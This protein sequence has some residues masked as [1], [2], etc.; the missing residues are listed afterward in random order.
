MTNELEKQFFDTF[1]IEHHIRHWQQYNFAQV[2]NGLKLFPERQKLADE[3]YIKITCNKLNPTEFNDCVYWEEYHYPQITDRI[4]LEL[5]IILGTICTVFDKNVDDL[6]EN[7]LKN[8]I[9]LSGRY[10][11]YNQVRTLFEEGD[12]NDR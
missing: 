4:L 3:G 12:N 10:H 2:E 9:E 11:I 8:L 1:G 6:K 7:V 5:I